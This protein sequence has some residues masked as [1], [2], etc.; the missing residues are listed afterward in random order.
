MSGIITGSFLCSLESTAENLCGV[1]TDSHNSSLQGEGLSP[2]PQIWRAH[3]SVRGT[4]LSAFIWIF[5]D[6]ECQPPSLPTKDISIINTWSYMWLRLDNDSYSFL[7]SSNLCTSS[8]IGKTY[9]H[10]CTHVHLC[11]HT[12]THTLMRHF[13][14]GTSQTIRKAL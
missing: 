6:A 7:N 13:L 11:P 5:R 4:G 1:Y 3:I 12:G 14:D 9:F 10:A 2:M 8:T